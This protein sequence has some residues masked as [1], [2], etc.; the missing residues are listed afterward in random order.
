MRNARITL[1]FVLAAAALAGC[2]V[3]D[4]RKDAS[5]QGVGA[6]SEGEGMVVSDPPAIQ[7]DAAVA[8][9]D[10]VLKSMSTVTGTT[11]SAATLRYWSVNK[12]SFPLNGA[13][14]EINAGAWMG[15]T[16][17]AGYVCND[18]YEREKQI[19]AGSPSRVCYRNLD[20]AATN[21]AVAF[22]NGTASVKDKVIDRLTLNAW[23]RTPTSAERSEFD[24]ALSSAGLLKP[25]LTQAELKDALLIL[26]TGSLAS[27][28]HLEH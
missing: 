17:L 21:N 15:Y 24:S 4:N 20:F 5:R 12:T 7:K 13:A 14:S 3:L 18:A 23:G 22:A 28:S 10:R 16:T 1:I 8:S 19:A 25:T 27:L 11:P 9:F 26:C 2:S 6:S